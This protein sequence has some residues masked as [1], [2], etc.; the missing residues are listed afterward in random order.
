VSNQRVNNSAYFTLLAD[1]RSGADMVMGRLNRHDS[2]CSSGGYPTA[3]LLDFSMPWLAD[4]STEKGCTMAFV[5][6]SLTSILSTMPQSVSERA[7]WIPPRCAADYDIASDPLKVHLKRFCT[8]TKQLKGDFSIDNIARIFMDAFV[9]EDQTLMACQ[10]PEGTRFRGLKVMADWL[11]KLPLATT[12]AVGAKVIRLTRRNLFERYMSFVTMSISQYWTVNNVADK[13]ARLKAF[14]TNHMA[15]NNGEKYTVDIDWILFQFELMQASDRTIN[16]WAEEY[17]GA[18]MWVD[19]EQVRD[20][21]TVAFTEM[22]DFL[23]VESDVEVIERSLQLQES[24]SF[25]SYNGQFLLSYIDNR[26]AVAEAFGAYGHG[27]FI[28]LSSYEPVHH[29]IYSTD[30]A[31]HTT[32]AR[33]GLEVTVVTAAQD[34]SVSLGPSAKFKSVLSSLKT[35][36]LDSVVVLSEGHTGTV[37]HHIK[38]LTAFYSELAKL[39]QIVAEMNQSHPGALLVSASTECCSSALAHIEPGTLFHLNGKRNSRTCKGNECFTGGSDSTSAAW[40]SFMKDRASKASKSDSMYLDGSFVAGT[41]RDLMGLI[42]ALDVDPLED[43]RAVLTD[44]MYQNPDKIVLDYDHNVFG[45]RIDGIASKID[46]SCDDSDSRFESS[47][48]PLFLHQARQPKCRVHT[49][50]P[51]GKSYPA[52]D[53]VGIP[54][55]P[56]LN[57]IEELFV[58]NKSLAHIDYHF[59]RE[60]LYVVDGAGFWGS[61]VTRDKYRVLPTEKFLGTAHDELL[62]LTAADPNSAIAHR[63]SGLRRTMETT[64]FPYWAWYGDWKFCAKKNMGEESI[65]LFTTCAS[66]DCEVRLLADRGLNSLWPC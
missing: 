17:G 32:T 9:E 65:P 28:G 57:H 8:F 29:V 55:K 26:Q 58:H 47:T 18:T 7:A 41:V 1:S 27:S 43:D 36:P 46:P 56:I 30:K 20:T 38:S 15:A 11:E 37:N 23:G 42:E 2:I 34:S 31:L 60:I 51:N 12:V 64:G 40:R 10:C 21:P 35:L 63:W 59:D 66:T 3:A 22:A 24:G 13:E 14:E 61:V 53:D 45:E 49:R 6:D 39:R 4:D 25:S 44:Y 50:N 19:Y 16:T 54:V 52:W 5:R 62:R 33:K 48:S